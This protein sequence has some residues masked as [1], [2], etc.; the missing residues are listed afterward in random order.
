MVVMGMV[1]TVLVL[2]NRCSCSS[3]LHPNGL[4]YTSARSS[5]DEVECM[6]YHASLKERFH[7]LFDGFG[8][9]GECNDEGRADRA[10]YWTR[11]RSKR[12]V[13]E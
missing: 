4:V 6:K 2:L 1:V 12:G 11:E 13:F 10:A 5:T 8:A 3:I 9:S 7:V